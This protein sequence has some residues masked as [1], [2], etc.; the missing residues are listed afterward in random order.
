MK[1]ILTLSIITML[2]M[3]LFVL[4]DEPPV[5]KNIRG[6]FTVNGQSMVGYIVEVT[7][8]R[9]GEVFSGDD[10]NYLITQS[11]GFAFDLRWFKQ[12]YEE[13]SKFFGYA[14]DVITVR[15]RGMTDASINFNVPSET[16]YSI[17]IAIIS[18][19]TVYVCPD[20]STVFNL[21]DCPEEE[22]E[23]EPEPEPEVEVETKVISSEDKSSASVEAY[24]GQTIDIC[25]TDNKV[26]SLLDKEIEYNGK[27][28]DIHEEAC[29]KGVI[30]TSLYDEDFGLNPYLIVVAGDATYGYY[31]EDAFPYEDVHAEIPLNIVVLGENY[32]IVYISEDMIV[33]RNGEK[34]FIEEGKTEEFNGKDV[35][36]K[37]IF[38]NDIMVDVAG[39]EQ[40]IN[41]GDSKEINGVNILVENILYK[42]GGPNYVELI[43]GTEGEVEIK[44]GDDYKDGEEYEWAIDMPN[45]IKVINQQDYNEID[46]DEEYK[47]IGIGG[48]LSLPNDYLVFNFKGISESDIVDLTFKVDDGY[49]NIK[50]DSNSDTFVF[51]SEE[52]DEINV[53]ID[54]IYDEDEILITTDKV[55]IGDSETYLELG[56]VKIGLLT[57]KLDMSDILYDGISYLSEEGNFLDYLGIIFKDPENAVEDQSGFKVLVPE[58][59][60]EVT[61]TI[62][63]E[64]IVVPDDDVVDD[65]VDDIVDD[66]IDDTTDDVIDDTIDDEDDDIVIPPPVI[67]YVCEDGTKV[68]SAEDCVKE[69]EKWGDT[70]FEQL[71]TVV[72][73]VLAALGVQWS[74]GILGIVR[75]HWKAG[76]K[77]QAMKTLFTLAKRAKEDYYKK[78]G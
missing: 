4:A 77:A 49:L 46:D 18:T 24:L 74:R 70:L 31:F 68:D 54:G 55:R 6:Y 15:I 36:I 76:R 29:F 25:V 5:P 27:D 19:Q 2:L 50:G 37:T 34:Y 7:N 51:G 38:E 26:S 10:Y 32:R 9:T 13:A 66:V 28:Y 43:I 44:D 47:A 53:N 73:A 65:T 21:A 61:L 12:G 3:S 8:T 58:E 45:Y 52:Y 33:V 40:S 64:A 78:K 17:T 20:G 41:D 16:P 75:Y 56:S 71:L 59:R 60:P 14:G 30:E 62:N 11:G 42:D 57:I 39:V 63:T 48:G 67:K 72:G 22:P 35:K 23:P 69:T 1:K